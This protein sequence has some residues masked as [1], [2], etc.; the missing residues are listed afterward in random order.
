[1]TGG[2]CQVDG[3]TRHTSHLGSTFHHHHLD[4]WVLTGSTSLATNALLCSSDHAALHGGTT[5]R[6]RDGRHAGP[7]GWS[8][9]GYDP[10][11]P[12]PF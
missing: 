4:P 3:C 12:P 11:P 2:W 10:H 9:P 6:L 8:P 5:L 1:M 7:H